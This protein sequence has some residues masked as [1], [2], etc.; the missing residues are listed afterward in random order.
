VARGRYLLVGTVSG[1]VAVSVTR[2]DGVRR[3]VTGASTSVLPGHTVFYDTGAW[4][5]GW[6]QVQLA[7][8]SIVTD[9]GRRAGVRSDS[10][11]G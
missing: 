2:P 11:T 6:D 7:P 9:D 10:W 1:D 4:D 5:E 8:L 3:P